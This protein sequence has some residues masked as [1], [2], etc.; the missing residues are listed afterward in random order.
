MPKDPVK[1]NYQADLERSRKPPRTPRDSM[2]TGA[3]QM[4]AFY[5]NLLSPKSNYTWNKIVV[6]QRESDPF[7]NFSRCLSGRPKG[8]AQ[9]VV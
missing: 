1:A 2:T 7:V 4:F 9:Q 6:K 3:S 5:T 8:N